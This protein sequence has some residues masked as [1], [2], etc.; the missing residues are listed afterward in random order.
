[1]SGLALP[2]A[3]QQQGQGQ[4]GQQQPHASINP[5]SLSKPP[6][7][8]NEIKQSQPSASGSGGNAVAGSSGSG[9]GTKVERPVLT[10][11]PEI[12]VVEG[13]VPTLQ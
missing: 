10:N 11:V 1:M 8:A 12:T 13:L 9:Q 5:S 7:G 4:Q 2:R 6:L 3:N